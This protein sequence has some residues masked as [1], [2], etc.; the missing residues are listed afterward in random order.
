M[1][2]LERYRQRRA[3]QGASIEVLSWPD[4]TWCVLALHAG[5]LGIVALDDEHQHELYQNA[6]M[7]IRDGC[8]PLLALRFDPHATH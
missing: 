8:L 2:R 5:P 3:K 6:G 1:Q 4:G 7:M